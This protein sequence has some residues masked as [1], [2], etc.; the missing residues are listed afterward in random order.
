MDWVENTRGL[1]E[2]ERLE[3][4]L[5]EHEEWGKD[6]RVVSEALNVPV[7][8]VLKVLVCFSRRGPLLAV[9][10]GDRRLDLDKLSKAARENVRLGRAR[11]VEALGFLLGGVPVVGSGIRTIVD[12]KVLQQRYVVGSAG[13]PYV[14]VKLKPEDLVR[15]N[16]ATVTE[17]SDQ[18]L[19]G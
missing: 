18:R 8:N 4:E 13:S 11:E 17:L 15:I 16:R 14:G 10:T 2:R 7:E 6:S 9:L 1:I 19:D 3:A 5:V 12:R